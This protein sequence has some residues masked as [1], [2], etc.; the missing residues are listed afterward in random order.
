MKD[1][2][3]LLPRISVTRPVTV[4]M[5][6]VALLVVGAVAYTR[7]PVKLF[8]S[9]FSPPFLYVSIRYPNSTPQETEQQIAR[10]LE[11][12]L[13]TIKGIKNIRTYSSTSGVSAPLQFRQDA[14][15]VLAYNQLIDQLDRLKP[16]LPEEA[17]DR[18]FVWKF[19]SENWS[20]MWVGV[21]LDST[22][23]DRYRF[24]DLHVRRPLERVDGVGKVEFWGVYEKEVMIEIDQ[25]RMRARGVNISEMVQSLQSDNFALAGGHVSQGGK[26]FF[27]RSLAR[28]RDLGEIENI[29][30]SNRNGGVRLKEVA[31]VFYDVP[32]RSWYERINGRPSVSIGIFQESGANIAAVCRRVRQVLKE[33]EAQTK[34]ADLQ[35][36]VFFDQGRF[37]EGSI[38]NLQTTG[39]WGGFFAALV[40]LF[41]LRTVRMTAII[42]LAIPLCVMITITVLYFVGW[43]LNVYTMMGLMVGVGMVV[44]NAIVILENIYRM[45]T[46]GE[47]PREGAIHGASEVGLAITM[48]TL[49]T[50]VVFLPLMLM[51]GDMAMTFFLSRIGVPVI[52]ALIGSLFVGLLFIPLASVKFGGSQVKADPASVRWVRKTYVRV[53][54]WTMWHRR[55]TFLIVIVLF[56][57][58]VY[59]S[60]NL[61]RGG[62]GGRA[63]NDFRISFRMPPDFSVQESGEVMAQ[64]EAY[65]EEKKE[66]YG[67]QTIRV[68][69]RSTY[70]SAQVFLKSNANDPWWWVVYRDVRKKLGYPVDQVMDRKNVINDIKKT[71]PRF[72]GVRT[73]VD[74]RSGS[75]SGGDPSVG[76]YL[77]GDDT[78]VLAELVEETERRLRTIPSV[79]SVDSDLERGNNEVQVHIN[80]ARAQK[81]GI[82]P[83][84]VGRSIAFALQGVS[85]PRYQA[86][87]REV[88]VRLYMEK[89]DRQTLHHLKNFVFPSRSGEQISLAEF[90]TLKVA[91]GRGTV[92]RENGKT[93]LRVKAFTTKD[94]LKG[95]YAEIDEVMEGFAMPRGYTWNKGERYSKLRETDNSTMSAVVMAITFVFLLMGVLF[96]SFVL[97]FSVLFS[98]PFA[99]LG[100]YWMLFLTGTPMTEMAMV[101]GIVLIGV[102]VNNAI[103]LVDMINRMRAEG[104]GRTEAILEAG[105]NR[106]RPILMTTFTTVFGLLPMALGSSTVLGEPYAPMG[107]TLIGGLLTSTLLTLLMVPLFYT[108]LDDLRNVLYRIT[109][110]AFSRVRSGNTS[111][112][113]VAEND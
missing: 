51:S 6:L 78:E 109:S 4:T 5:C 3:S 86:N 68:W 91:Q 26:K 94:D 12:R 16:E 69:F 111:G 67:I 33:I 23:T 85:L 57:T 22:I 35:F 82:S 1:R 15:M 70:G 20:I 21:A 62:G 56:A 80:R 18:L 75:G 48:A 42:T 49:T 84:M 95:L 104:M 59:P 47:A 31:D 89:L 37:I 77:Y 11:E 19:N 13:R 46:R 39:I 61:K 107:R 58:I 81:Y 108:L 103:V 74:S 17:R 106:F 14:D 25:D 43:S 45:R 63:L 38:D 97:P 7:I 83:R 29:Q 9:G 88:N 100:V 76:V 34:T 66:V 92:R 55:D 65:L 72:V 102:V 27:V 60:Q 30:V 44:D 73:S 113:D 110:D 54:G 32:L 24:L 52:V 10:P 79:I 2:P 28:Y 50:V 93:R 112:L 8:P 98:I 40:L 87:E 105:Y 53:L 64:V 71:A 36:N 96:E 101:G 41:Y 90:A 99:F